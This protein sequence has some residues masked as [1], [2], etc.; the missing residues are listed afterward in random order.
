[1]KHYKILAQRGKE[2]ERTLSQQR[3]QQINMQEPLS[4]YFS[5]QLHK[6]GTISSQAISKCPTQNMY[7]FKQVLFNS[8][9]SHALTNN[10]KS[11][12]CSLPVLN[13]KNK[14]KKPTKIKTQIPTT[15][16]ICIADTKT[17]AKLKC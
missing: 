15:I 1:M 9:D 12:L 14:L 10:I 8:K 17:E 13:I 2:N 11:L 7:T 3:S 4:F 16:T 6:K 5:I